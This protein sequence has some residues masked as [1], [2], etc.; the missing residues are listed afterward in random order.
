MDIKEE[1]YFFSN[2][3]HIYFWKLLFLKIVRFCT[4]MER[5]FFVYTCQSIFYYYKFFFRRV[6]NGK[7]KGLLNFYN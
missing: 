4:F 3:V 5:D 7:Q 2:I 1:R 6:S